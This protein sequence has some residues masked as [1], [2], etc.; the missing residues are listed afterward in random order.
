MAYK[1]RKPINQFREGKRISNELKTREVKKVKRNEAGEPIGVE[2]KKLSKID[3]KNAPQEVKDA[4]GD[5]CRVGYLESNQDHADHFKKTKENLSS[6]EILKLY[7]K[8]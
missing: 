1:N 6:D 8:K 2:T 5:G 3:Y 7:G 4:F